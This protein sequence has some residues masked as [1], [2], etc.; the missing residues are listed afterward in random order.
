MNSGSRI[1]YNMA[2]KGAIRMFNVGENIVYGSN[3]V[4]KVENIGVLDSPGMPQDKEYY[5]LCPIYSKGSKIF[6]PV[7]N[8]K[9]I[10]RAVLG[11]DEAQELINNIDSI[12]A[13]WIADEKSRESEYK[14]AIKACNCKELVKIIKT[15]YI[16][17]QDRIANGKKIT[18]SDEKYFRMAEDRLYGELAVS[19]DISKEEIKEYIIEHCKI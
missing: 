11:K 3:G 5:T 12:E 14:E 9:I 13:L 4:C 10:M 2:Y 7:D 18:A 17:M 19:L 16:R 15:I 1:C 8:D 6:T